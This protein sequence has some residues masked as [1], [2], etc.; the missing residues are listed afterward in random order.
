MWLRSIDYK[1]VLVLISCCWKLNWGYIREWSLVFRNYTELNINVLSIEVNKYKYVT[2]Y[3]GK[4]AI[5]SVSGSQNSQN[6]KSVCVYREND[7]GS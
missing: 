6:I 2:K 5:V 1:T 3:S 4:G 7:K